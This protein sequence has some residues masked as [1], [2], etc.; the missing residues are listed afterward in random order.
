VLTTFSTIDLSDVQQLNT[1]FGRLSIVDYSNT[2]FWQN[3]GRNS[4]AFR[5]LFFEDYFLKKHNQKE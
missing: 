3:I 5:S 2:F 4:L 1:V